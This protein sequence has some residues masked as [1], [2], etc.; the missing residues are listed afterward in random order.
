M[1]AGHTPGENPDVILTA[2]AVEDRPDVLPFFITFE[3]VVDVP[4][5]PNRIRVQYNIDSRSSFPTMKNAS[6]SMPDKKKA[7][8]TV[9]MYMEKVEEEVERFLEWRA[10]RVRT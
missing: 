3:D 6:S 5:T 9:K 1:Y 10:G 7:S 8:V 2:K 4:G